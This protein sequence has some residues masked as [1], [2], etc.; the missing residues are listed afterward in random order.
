MSTK[1]N[2][3]LHDAILLATS[4]HGDKQLRMVRMM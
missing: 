2:T 4:G 1:G 3:L